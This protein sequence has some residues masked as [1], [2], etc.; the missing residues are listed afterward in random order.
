M[1]NQFNLTVT[2]LHY[3]VNQG[4]TSEPVWDLRANGLFPNNPDAIVFA[5][6]TKT[7][8]SPDGPNNVPWVELTKDSGQLANLVYRLNTVNGQP[9]PAVS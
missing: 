7:A 3:F 6:K 1:Q 5:H 2:G 9:P 8:P 4:N